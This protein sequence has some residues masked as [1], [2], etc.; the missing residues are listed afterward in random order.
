[1]SLENR[2]SGVRSVNNLLFLIDLV[3]CFGGDD[4]HDGD[5]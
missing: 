1:M 5:C 4:H 3:H 2:M